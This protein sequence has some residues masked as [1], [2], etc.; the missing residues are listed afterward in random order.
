MLL[1]NA[2]GRFCSSC[3]KLNVKTKNDSRSYEILQ[4]EDGE[5]KVWNIEEGRDLISEAFYFSL[6]LK[7]RKLR[8]EK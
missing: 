5:R 1:A 7:V 4:A 8:G 3:H 2:C 6:L